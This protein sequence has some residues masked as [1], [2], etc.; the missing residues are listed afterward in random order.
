M[1][2]QQLSANIDHKLAQLDGKI[3]KIKEQQAK[4]EGEPNQLT[5]D[6]AAL[7]QIKRKLQKSQSIMWQ[8][9]DLQRDGDQRALRQRRLLG[10]GLM[11][12]SGLGLLGIIA[13]VLLR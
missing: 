10:I 4:G 1:N 2:I 8:A 5:K 11:V 12:F 9:H 13:I 3:S 7:E 6:L